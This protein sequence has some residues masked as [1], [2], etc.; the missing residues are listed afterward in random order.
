MSLCFT[1]LQILPDRNF[2]QGSLRKCVE[3]LIV[4]GVCEVTVFRGSRAKNAT[5]GGEFGIGVKRLQGFQ[6]IGLQTRRYTVLQTVRIRVYCSE[7]RL[8]PTLMQNHPKDSAGK[9]Q[10]FE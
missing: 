1:Y 4:C 6:D 10:L 7:A 9:L 8:N 2:N 3:R 5:K